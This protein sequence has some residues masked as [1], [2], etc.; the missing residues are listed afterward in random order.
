MTYR[1]RK[2]DFVRR[3]NDSRKCGCPFKFRGNQWL[4]DKDEKIIIANM[5]KSMMKLRNILLTLKEHNV[6]SCTTIKQIYN[7][8]SAYRSSIRGS[9][10]EMQHLM[11]LKDE[12]VVR[13]IS[14][15]HPDAVKLCNACNLVFLI[16]ST[17]KTNRYRLPLL[18]FVGVIPTGMTFSVERFRYLFLRRDVLLKVIVTDKDLTLMNVVKNVFPECTNLLCRFHNDKNVK[19]KCKS[20]IEY[21]MDAWE[22]LVNCC[23]EHQFD[24]CLKKFEITCSSWSMFVDYVNKTWI[25]THREKFVK[26]WT[27]KVMHLGNTTTNRVDEFIEAMNNMIMLQ[28]TEIKASFETSTHVF[29]HEAT[30]HDLKIV[31]EYG[32]V[33]YADKNPFRCGCVMRITH[34]FPCACELYI[35]FIGTIPLETIH[36]FWQMLSFSDQRLSESQVTITK[37][38]KT[39][40]K[41]FEELDVC[42]KYVDALHSMQNSNSSVKRSASSSD[43]AIPIRTMPILDQFH[44]F[45]HD[46]IENIMDVKTGGNCGYHAIVALLSMSEDS[47]SLVPSRL[48]K[49]LGKW[50]DEYINLFGGIDKFEEL[51]RSLLVDGLSMVTMDKWMDITN[52]GYVYLRDRCPLPALALLWSRNCHPEAKQWPTL[53]ISRMHQYRNLM[54]LKRD[55]V[56]LSE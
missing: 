38:I 33:H 39:I 53:C 3:D 41:R 48:L 16:D 30:W 8:R 50:F 25:I 14:G 2:K 5:K 37:E 28:H 40:S 51:K 56:D 47:W 45:I 24:D 7:A 55:Y 29:E 43:L 13:D 18:D 36:M 52:M 11:K 9:D 10:T 15:C 20:L 17:Y 22:S 26:V 4:E 32:R 49:E 35:Y 54:M 44:P 21:V 1:S 23:F 42:D 27:N 19:A 12:D 31:A 34:G 46:S 6:N